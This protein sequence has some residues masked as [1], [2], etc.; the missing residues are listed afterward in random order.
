MVYQNLPSPL[1]RLIEAIVGFV[2]LTGVFLYGKREMREAAIAYRIAA[3]KFQSKAEAQTKMMERW[4][5]L[6]YC[7]R[8]DRVFD[9]SSGRTAPSQ[10]MLDLLT[11]AP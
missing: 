6:S 4:E 9:P 1:D 5:R 8:C 10:Q 2:A 3:L 11:P 7:G